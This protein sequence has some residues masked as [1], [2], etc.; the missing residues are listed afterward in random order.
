M[1]CPR[2]YPPHGL[3]PTVHIQPKLPVN[4][5]DRIFQCWTY[6]NYPMYE[7]KIAQKRNK[8]STFATQNY[9]FLVFLPV[10]TTKIVF[11]VL[12]V[13][14]NLYQIRYVSHSTHKR[15]YFG[16]NS[17]LCHPIRPLYS[18]IGR[19]RNYLERNL[20]EKQSLRT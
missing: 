9:S 14:L 7:E 17:E 19:E 18:R 4:T 11:C 12:L 6:E 1:R 3:F 5:R 13:F 8:R 16:C 10:I 2:F 20:T 15:F